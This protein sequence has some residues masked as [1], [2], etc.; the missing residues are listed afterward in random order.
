[1]SPD[2]LDSMFIGDV[3]LDDTFRPFGVEQEHA[4]RRCVARPC[5]LDAPSTPV[6]EC[7]KRVG[8]ILVGALR[9]YDLPVDE[10]DRVAPDAR[11]LIAAADQVHLDPALR[12]VPH[13]PVFERIQ[14]ETGTEFTIDPN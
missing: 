2:Q 6:N 14:I 5:G 3:T 13:G 9:V 10:H 7:L 12:L 4:E 11:R 8:P 1:M